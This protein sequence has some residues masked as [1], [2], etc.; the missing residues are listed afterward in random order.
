[1]TT[2]EQVRHV[3]LDEPAP[4]DDTR[5]RLIRT[6]QQALRTE[7]PIQIRLAPIARQAGL[8][9]SAVY[10]HFASREDL[11]CA[12]FLENI[13]TQ[14]ARQ[15]ERIQQ[16]R[17]SLAT[18]TTFTLEIEEYARAELTRE[19]LQ[20]R[21]QLA[22]ACLHLHAVPELRSEA[23]PLVIDAMESVIELVERE[24]RAGNVRTDM[25]AEALG[26]LIWSCIDGLA[27]WSEL[28]GEESYNEFV[29]ALMQL[30]SPLDDSA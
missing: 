15:K 22:E 27:L 11:L 28:Y 12:A 19:G 1:M 17:T 3:F 10:C 23:T 4:I 26:V 13:K 18:R 14:V 16:V 21:R 6:T 24:Q 20:D 8:T 7:L 25:S 5:T 29:D 30:V 2:Y 9:T